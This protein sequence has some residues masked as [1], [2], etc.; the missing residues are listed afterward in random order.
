MPDKQVKNYFSK[1]VIFLYQFQFNL[2]HIYSNYH[3]LNQ[4]YFMG[5]S[6]I[7]Y[8]DALNVAHVYNLIKF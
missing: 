1:A 4:T 3:V 6:L 8:T 7:N 2:I 5:R